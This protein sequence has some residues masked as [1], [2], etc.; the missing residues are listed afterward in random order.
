MGWS[1]GGG[2][3]GPPRGGGFGG[4]RGGFGGGG[5]RGRGGFGDRG[6]GGGGFGGGDRGRGG[7][8]GRGRG[9][10]GGRGRGR[11][12]RGGGGPKFEKSGP[13]EPR[14]NSTVQIFVEG[15]PEGAKIPELVQYFSTVGPI[16]GDKESKKPRVWLYTDKETKMVQTISSLL[17]F[18]T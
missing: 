5:D 1:T 14:I 13:D 10:G 3:S 2:V 8:G 9:G 6:R 15:L 17:H 18:L 11:G 4:D 7:G 12:G 16:K